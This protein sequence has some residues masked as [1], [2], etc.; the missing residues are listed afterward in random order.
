MDGREGNRFCKRNVDKTNS[1]FFTVVGSGVKTSHYMCFGQ[2]VY[3]ILLCNTLKVYVPPP[4]L[5]FEFSNLYSPQSVAFLVHITV[6]NFMRSYFKCHLN[7]TLLYNHRSFEWPLFADSILISV[8]ISYLPHASYIFNLITLTGIQLET[9][10]NYDVSCYVA[11]SI[12]AFLYLASKYSPQ[13]FIPQHFQSVFS[14][15]DENQI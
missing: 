2:K 12:L 6:H 15:W 8:S 3:Y 11:F 9:V 13:N 1:V 5:C 4:C 14:S 10:Q 7:I